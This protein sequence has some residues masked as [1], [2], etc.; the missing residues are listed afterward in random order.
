MVLAAQARLLTVWWVTPRRPRGAPWRWHLSHTRLIE[1]L[2][3]KCFRMAM[4]RVSMAAWLGSITDL[5][6]ANVGL[7][8][9]RLC[10]IAGAP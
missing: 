10:T 5:S 2:D 1:A 3:P 8:G 9:S 6:V 4:S 7:R